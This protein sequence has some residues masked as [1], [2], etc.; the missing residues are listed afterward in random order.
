MPATLIW[1]R[2]SLGGS[3]Q[4]S[5]MATLIIIACMFATAKGV[6]QCWHVSP[7]RGETE[8]QKYFLPGRQKY[9][10]ALVLPFLP[11]RNGRN[12]GRNTFSPV[13][14]LRAAEIPFG[15]AKNQHWTVLP[16]FIYDSVIKSA[17][18]AQQLAFP[19]YFSSIKKNL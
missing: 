9:L 11:G 2:Q 18:A 7:R 15:P 6:L 8:R 19:E 14:P 3:C 16:C 5:E 12:Y 1:P 10:L 13:S 4:S 17:T